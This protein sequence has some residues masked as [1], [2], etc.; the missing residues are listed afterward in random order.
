M[1]CLGYRIA[2]KIEDVNV[3]YE[4]ELIICVLDIQPFNDGHLFILPKNH[5]LDVDEITPETLSSKS[6]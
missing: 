4:D 3:V 5:F 1:E 6:F 2:N